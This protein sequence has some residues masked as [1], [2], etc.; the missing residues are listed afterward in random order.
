M[1]SPTCI[2]I[3]ECGLDTTADIK[4]DE[5]VEAFKLQLKLAKEL[6]KP[7]VIH[8][9]GKTPEDTSVLYNQALDIC[10]ANLPRRHKLHLHCVDTN[11]V[12][13]QH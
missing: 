12:D 9:R 3:G 1:R 6:N 13:L 8:L 5:Q 11:F 7:V 10:K 2:A 4:L